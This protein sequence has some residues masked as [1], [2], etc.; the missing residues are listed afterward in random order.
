MSTRKAEPDSDRRFFRSRRQSLEHDPAGVRAGCGK[1]RPL[2]NPSPQGGGACRPHLPFPHQ[3]SARR[4]IAAVHVVQEAA[5]GQPLPLVGRGWGG[6]FFTP[7]KNNFPSP[8][9]RPPNL[10]LH[11]PRPAIGYTGERHRRGGTGA[12][13]WAQTHVWPR[14]TVQKMVSLSS[15]TMARRACAAHTE[16]PATGFGANAGTFRDAAAVKAFVRITE[17]GCR[18]AFPEGPELH[19]ADH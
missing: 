19:G 18:Y 8:H 10:C 9:P 16:D 17:K 15:A 5:P 4:L 12:W 11:Y 3:Q 7:P 1:R 13:G 2:P 14:G 6:V